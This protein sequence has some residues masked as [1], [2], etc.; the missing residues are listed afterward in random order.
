M[1]VKEYLNIN[2]TSLDDSN[3]KYNK[4]EHMPFPT[5]EFIFNET[6]IDMTSKVGENE[7]QAT[8]RYITKLTMNMI[9]SSINVPDTRIMLEFLIAKDKNYRK[10]FIDTVA[11]VI[12]T[13]RYEGLQEIMKT[14]M[15]SKND[16]PKIVQAYA[17]SNGLLFQTYA[18][19]IPK[20]V[21]RK[22]Y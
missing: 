20:D 9:R 1:F 21:I 12:S 4:S 22:D 7:A 10:G 14:G 17:K 5:L 15:L 11:S 8:L 19:Y 18:D 2:P 16:L 6:A 13:A 3:Q